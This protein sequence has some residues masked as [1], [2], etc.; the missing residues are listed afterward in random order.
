VMFGIGGTFVEALKDVVFA[1]APIGATTAERTIRSIRA[2]PL[3]EAFRGQPAVDLDPLA[4]ILTALGQLGLDFPE[5][6]EVDL[7]PVIADQSGA[8]AVDLL[9]KLRKPSG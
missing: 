2:F 8:A 5:I 4:S 6:E 7:N 1:V 3:L 9:I